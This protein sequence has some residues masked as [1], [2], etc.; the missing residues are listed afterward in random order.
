M[1][2]GGSPFK[3]S[4]APVWTAIV[5]VSTIMMLCGGLLIGGLLLFQEVVLG[6]AEN[7]RF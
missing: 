3:K 6:L 2:V 1:S 7:G 5:L 4:N